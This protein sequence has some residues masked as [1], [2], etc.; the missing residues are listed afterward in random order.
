M[1]S[2]CTHM[3]KIVVGGEKNL[4]Y[5]YNRKNIARPFQIPSQMREL[6]HS[7]AQAPS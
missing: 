1:I 5:I 2:Y 7:E 3:V 6:A 4:S